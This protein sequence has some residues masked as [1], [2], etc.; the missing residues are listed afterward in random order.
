[1][2]YI[3]G[4]QNFIFDENIIEN[5]TLVREKKHQNNVLMA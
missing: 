2:I 1:M 5:N 4:A 3:I